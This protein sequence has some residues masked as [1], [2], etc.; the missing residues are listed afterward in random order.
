MHLGRDT[1]GVALS[2]HRRCK[3]IKTL[4]IVA[5]VELFVIAY[6]LITIGELKHELRQAEDVKQ[7]LISRLKERGSR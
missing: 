3:M 5:A 7:M 6:L 1:R 4:I 2:K